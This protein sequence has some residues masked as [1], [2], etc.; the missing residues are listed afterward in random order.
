MK[1]AVSASSSDDFDGDDRFGTAKRII[2]GLGRKK[3]GPADPASEA[4]ILSI[5]DL[6]RLERMLDAIFDATSWQELLATP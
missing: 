3:F 5:A 4:A 1:I 6:S 2:I